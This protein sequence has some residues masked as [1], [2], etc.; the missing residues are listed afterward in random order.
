VLEDTRTRE[1]RRRL[2]FDETV[3][4]ELANRSRTA[5]DDLVEASER[6][7]HAALGDDADA[8]AAQF[9]FALRRVR[10]LPGFER[11]ATSAAWSDV[12]SAVEPNRPFIYVNPTPHGT[13]VLTLR[14]SDADAPVQVRA[15]NLDVTSTAISRKVMLGLDEQ[16]EFVGPGYLA[17]LS[18]DGPIGEALSSLL[19]WVGE[20]VM[21]PVVA[22]LEPDERNVVLTVSGP[23]ATVP[24][25]AAQWTEAEGVV[26]V[27]D[28]VALTYA[29]SA[30][31]HGAALRLLAEQTEPPRLVAVAD[32]EHVGAPLPGT[33]TEVAEISEHFATDRRQ[34]AVADDATVAFVEAHTPHATH[35]HLACHAEGS[36]FDRDESTVRLADGVLP[37]ARLSA[38]GGLGSRM[39][40]L[41]ACESAVSDITDRADEAYSMASVVLASGSPGVI[42]SLW[43]VDDYATA[44]LMARTYEL[45]F[46]DPDLRP[47][48]AL[49]DAQTWLRSLDDVGHTAYLNEHPLLASERARRRCRPG[50]DA[51]NEVEGSFGDPELWAPFIAMGA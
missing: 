6:L 17:A 3:M 21:A 18:N 47:A 29:P 41:S 12:E 4:Q 46:A 10:S 40:V 34:I 43:P 31:L 16:G 35:V 37:L 5:H 51:Q 27:A 36:L 20:Q 11:F 22:S 13:L 45:L 42:A 33:R 7:R 23:L 1:L 32:P 2:G 15:D 38:L 24:L 14:R 30:V 28:T 49:C 9:D 26:H 48:E 8:A 44:L 50:A 25:H 19:P 39:T